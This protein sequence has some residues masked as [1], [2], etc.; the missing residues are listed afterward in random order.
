MNNH[1]RV[2]CECL[3]KYIDIMGRKG[4]SRTALEYCKLL[5][6]LSPEN[7]PQG[8][9]LRMDYYADRAREYNYLLRLIKE[10]PNEIYPE[11]P[12]ASLLVLPNLLMTA[13]LAGYELKG[14]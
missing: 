7:D 2:F 6:G 9:L 11:E 5:L 4:C 12:M 10:L 14:G 8:T 1:Y 13:A 3:V